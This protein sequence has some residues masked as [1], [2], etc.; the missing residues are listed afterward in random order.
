M[1]ISNAIAR[2]LSA[3][4][5]TAFLAS[6]SGA[7]SRLETASAQI[8]TSV[9]QHDA[10]FNVADLA[11][12][13]FRALLRDRATIR[14]A[15]IHTAASQTAGRGFSGNCC[16]L[17]YASDY[18]SGIVTGFYPEGLS[19]CQLVGLP[20]PLG[21]HED[22]AGDLFVALAGSSSV[23]EFAPRCGNVIAVFKDLAGCS[24][25]DVTVDP[26][27]G[28]NFGK[29]YVSNACGSGG[30][31]IVNYTPPCPPPNG[32]NPN[33]GVLSD[34][35]T[36]ENF[37]LAFDANGNL[38]SS[39]VLANQT[40]QVDCYAGAAGAARQILA[41]PAIGYPGGVNA[42]ANGTRVVVVD[43]TGAANQA[44]GIKTYLA[45]KVCTAGAYNL[46]AANTIFQ[47]AGSDYIDISVSR[48]ENT[49]ANSLDINRVDTLLCDADAVKFSWFVLLGAVD[50]KFP[51]P[52]CM[53]PLG[54]TQIETYE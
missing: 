14:S 36:L 25:V 44:A 9:R 4:M 6:C 3:A 31:N 43:Q 17:V 19:P 10:R 1:R 33:A 42:L 53:Q 18:T 23:V 34:P 22:A 30:P 12:P 7:T 24:P 49:E 48:P 37:W 16:K 20:N 2:I 35:R 11:A 40:G 46:I 21:M 45:H 41:L 15:A 51:I 54:V 26:A 50:D 28:P 47:P 8:P 52:Q 29:V 13:Q 32:C 38:F 39:V 5:L 27:A